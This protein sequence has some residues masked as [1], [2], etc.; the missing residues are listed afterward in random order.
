M[1]G[2]KYIILLEQK[3]QIELC[4]A[5]VLSIPSLLPYLLQRISNSQHG[6]TA[7]QVLTFPHIQMNF[8]MCLLGDLIGSITKFHDSVFYFTI[9][10]SV[11]NFTIMRSVFHFTVMKSVFKSGL[12]I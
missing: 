8:C 11:F 2:L 6:Y 1:P 3:S 5:L 7:N 4:I 12:Y 10:K 9:M